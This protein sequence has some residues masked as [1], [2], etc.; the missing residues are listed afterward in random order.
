M[1]FICGCASENKE[2]DVNS[3]ETSLLSAYD[4]LSEDEKL[5]FDALTIALKNFYN[6]SKVRLLEAGAMGEDSITIKVQGTN[7]AGGT[8]TESYILYFKNHQDGY[9]YYSKRYKGDVYKIDFSYSH[10]DVSCSKI[11]KAL[12]E[13][14]EEQGID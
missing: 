11:N 4:Q 8:I 5:V 1:L 12:K 10:D 3:N 7:M 14:W 6:P 9:N 2:V 13:Y